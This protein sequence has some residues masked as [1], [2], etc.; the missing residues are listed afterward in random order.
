MR[1]VSRLTRAAEYPH[2]LTYILPAGCHDVISQA[3]EA[4][5]STSEPPTHSGI[6]SSSG[7]A[8][9]SPGVLSS[10]QPATV[11]QADEGNVEQHFTGCYWDGPERQTQS[12]VCVF[13]DRE[14]EHVGH[15]WPGSPYICFGGEYS[16]GVSSYKTAGFSVLDRDKHS[17]HYN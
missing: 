6:P 3:V 1:S 14:P 16:P 12:C 17:I 13:G 8:G 4:Q 2:Y 9:R 11:I 15:C 5:Q 7:L 10:Q